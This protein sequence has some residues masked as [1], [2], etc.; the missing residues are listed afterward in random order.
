M[1]ALYMVVSNHM[2]MSDYH[3]DVI[4][5]RYGNLSGSTFRISSGF[6]VM[7]MVKEQCQYCVYIHKIHTCKSHDHDHHILS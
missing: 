2:F 7:L 3:C 5:A 6:S 1:P 4:I